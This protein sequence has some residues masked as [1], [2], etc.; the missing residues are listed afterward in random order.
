MC[1]AMKKKKTILCMCKRKKTS[2]RKKNPQEQ[3]QRTNGKKI[4]ICSFFFR[5][6]L[7]FGYDSGTISIA[8]RIFNQPLFSLTQLFSS[9]LYCVLTNVHI[10]RNEQTNKLLKKRVSQMYI[11]RAH[12]TIAE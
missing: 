8:C 2:K 10:F 5:V 3:V 12:L 4:I 1:I 9:S 7:T 6:A 11:V